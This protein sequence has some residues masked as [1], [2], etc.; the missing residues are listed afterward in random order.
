MSFAIRLITFPLCLLPGL[1]C[2]GGVASVWP[3][4]A[5]C[6]T[7]L[8]ACVDATPE[9]G[10]VS[11][12][13]DTPIAENINLYNRSISLVAAAGRKPNFASGNWISVTAAPIHGNQDVTLRGLRLTNA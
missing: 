9:G 3:G 4:A 1:A 8:Q 13:T 5:P 7:T 10:T 6:N 11:I 2:A 12:A